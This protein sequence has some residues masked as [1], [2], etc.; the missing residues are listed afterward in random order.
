VST[1][2]YLPTDVKPSKSA[3]KPRRKGLA[4][5]T[6]PQALRRVIQFGF[7]AFIAGIATVNVLVDEAGATITASWEAYCP[8]GGLETLYKYV[9][10]GGS[11]V[12]HTHLSNLIVLVAALVTSL[13]MRNAFC[14]WV[15][16]LGFIQDLTSSFSAF[17]QKRVKPVRQGVKWLKTR[18]AW[19]AVVDKPLRLLKYAV[20]IW[21][22]TGAAI[23]GVMVFRD[24]DPWA[25]LWNLTELSLGLGT[26]V[27]GVTL[28][29]SL[30]VERPWC[31]YACPLGAATGLVSKLSPVYLKRE[32]GACKSCAICTKA[33]PMGLPVHTAD[34]IKSQD[35]IGCLECVGD[36]P[37]EGALELK[38]GLPIIGK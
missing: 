29:A 6:T 10:T 38:L 13:L 22:V 9:T 34:T 25:A 5:L 31:R 27:L 24:Y 8:M 16:P 4:R 12:S 23:Y 26:L 14:G 37:R 30:F 17:V 28:V 11:F 3:I 36:C 1:Q 35:C 15:C 33:C 7:L 2:L 21:A 19:L 18:M 32:S 20:L